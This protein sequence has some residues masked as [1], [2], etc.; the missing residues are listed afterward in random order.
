M[1]RKTMITLAALTFVGAMTASSTVDARMGG[2]GFG[3]GGFHGGFGG[4]GF[5][6]GFGGGG[7]RG[8]FVGP[9]RFG[10]RPGIGPRFAFHNRVFFGNRFFPRR[11][12]AFAAVPF[13]VGLGFYGSSC[14]SWQ[15]TAWGWQRVWVCGYD[16]GNGFGGYGY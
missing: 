14:W 13:G 6:G 1:L 11:R 16:Y 9:S 10:F 7:F 3:G 8:G 15:P 12:F 4:G 2:V 5:R